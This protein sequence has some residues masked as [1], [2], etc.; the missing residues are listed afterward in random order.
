MHTK[1][2][3][4]KTIWILV[5]LCSNIYRY[6]VI[7]N[8]SWVCNFFLMLPVNIVCSLKKKKTNTA[9]SWLNYTCYATNKYNIV[10]DRPM[11]PQTLWPGPGQH[12]AG[13]RLGHRLVHLYLLSGPDLG[14]E[15]DVII[16]LKASSICYTSRLQLCVPNGKGLKVECE[17]PHSA[18]L[19]NPAKRRSHQFFLGWPT[20]QS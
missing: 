14:Q 6:A 10:Q 17:P 19:Y 2:S 5:L 3:N 20:S 7:M 8:P 13:L 1:C 16:A 18:L 4:N 12:F 15:L 11:G 9:Q